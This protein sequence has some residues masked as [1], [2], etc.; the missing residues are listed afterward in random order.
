MMYGKL[1]LPLYAD[2][3]LLEVASFTKKDSEKS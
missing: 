1:T 3:V 2:G